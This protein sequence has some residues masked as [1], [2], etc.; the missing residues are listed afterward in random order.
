[1]QSCWLFFI[2]AL[3]VRRQ[4]LFYKILNHFCKWDK[5]TRRTNIHVA[6]GHTK[7]ELGFVRV[8]LLIFFFFGP[9]LFWATSGFTPELQVA[10]A[11]WYFISRGVYRRG[12]YWIWKC[13]LPRYHAYLRHWVPILST[14][15]VG[16]T[17][18]FHEIIKHTV[19]L[20][21]M[22]LFYCSLVILFYY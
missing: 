22:F 5:R 7:C 11:L 3:P 14:S 19:H 8:Q 15:Y 16:A 13:S 6:C 9:N 20:P 4:W 2:I 12:K 18:L 10:A 17:H 1:M 21:K